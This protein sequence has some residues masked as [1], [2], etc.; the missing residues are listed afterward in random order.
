MIDPVNSRWTIFPSAGSS[1]LTSSVITGRRPSAARCAINPCPISP[2]APVISTDRLAYHC[3]S[4][5]T[6]GRYTLKLAPLPRSLST[7]MAPPVCRM[8]P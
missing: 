7:V 6:D 5:V 2:P 3:D 1:G 8:I 4:P